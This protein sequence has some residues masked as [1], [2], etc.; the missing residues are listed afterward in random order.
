MRKSISRFLALLLTLALAIPMYS[1]LV[2][3]ASPLG[4]AV[5]NSEARDVPEAGATSDPAAKTTGPPEETPAAAVEEELGELPE[6]E[7][8]PGGLPEKEAPAGDEAEEEAGAVGE[9]EVKEEEG[10]VEEEVEEEDAEEEEEEG[11]ELY[12]QAV[13]SIE[14]SRIRVEVDEFMNFIVYQRD[15]SSW[16]RVTQPITAFDAGGATAPGVVGAWS[17]ALPWSSSTGV[18]VTGDEPNFIEA[19]TKLLSP[20]TSYITTGNDYREVANGQAGLPPEAGNA[21][22]EV[23]LSDNFIRVGDGLYESNVK[24]YT[25]KGAATGNRLTVEGVDAANSLKHTVVLE[26]G[27]VPGTIAVSSYYT[28]EGAGSFK[29]TKF[30]DN[31][32]KVEATPLENLVMGGDTKRTGGLWS[33]QGCDSGLSNSWSQGDKVFPVLDTMGAGGTVNIHANGVTT[34][35]MSRN[36]WHWTRIAG[37]A[38]NFLWGS[39]V[40]FGVGSLMPYHVFGLELPVRGSGIAGNHN[41]GYT[42]VGWPGKTLETGEMTYIGTSLIGV[43]DGDMGSGVDMYARTMDSVDLAPFVERGDFISRTDTNDAVPWSFM[44]GGRDYASP[45]YLTASAYGAN[46]IDGVPRDLITLPKGNELP[47]W[48]RKPAW[49]TFGYGSTIPPRTFFHLVPILAR[50]G[51]GSVVYESGWYSGGIANPICMP[52]IGGPT[53]TLSVLAPMLEEYFDEHPHSKHVTA[54]DAYDFSGLNTDDQA[55]SIR[56]VRAMNEYVHEH[57]MKVMGWVQNANISGGNTPVGGIPLSW[58][59]ANASNAR[60][61]SYACMGNPEVINTL[62][63]YIS[64]Y[65]FGDGVGELNFD[66]FKGDSFWGIERCF[67]TGHGH[68]GDPDAPIRNYGLFFKNLYDK[69]N[70]VKG[71]TAYVGGPIIDVE[72]MSV[73]KHC[74][75]GRIM[76]YYVYAG[77][78]RPI[79]GDHSGTKQNRQ[80]NRIFRGFYGWEVP[81][82]SDHHDLD[83]RDDE[84]F[85]PPLE[86]IGEFDYANLL[87]TGILFA[88]KTR[89]NLNV[90]ESSTSERSSLMTWPGED[91]YKNRGTDFTPSNGTGAN[92]N[93]PWAN[94]AIKWGAALKY[95]G[96]YN[97]FMPV[98]SRMIDNLYKYVVDYPEAYALELMDRNA[99]GSLTPKPVSERIYSFYATSFAIEE[100]EPRLRN[101]TGAGA[102][103]TVPCRFY[104]EMMLSTTNNFPRS[105]DPWNSTDKG[106]ENTTDDIQA[107]IPFTFKYEGPIEIR[108]LKASTAYCLTDIETGK[109]LLKTSDVNGLIKF[110]VVFKNSVIYH[111]TEANT[112]SISGYVYDGYGD[113]LSGATITLYDENGNRMF[114]DTGSDMDGFYSFPIVPTG[115]YTLKATFP[116]EYTQPLARTGTA[117]DYEPNNDSREAGY[118]PVNLDYFDNVDEDYTE[119][120]VSGNTATTMDIEFDTDE[121]SDGAIKVKVFKDLSMVVYRNEGT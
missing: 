110:D 86:N 27:N 82:D 111:V 79:H 89:I 59:V 102:W 101:V 46:D 29:I 16:K 11:Q 17:Y 52:R 87:G 96:L 45:R 104:R 18:T 113:I 93:L 71:A 105:F 119:V 66:G 98:Q 90:Y 77:I 106:I 6:K 1:P 116:K 57:G 75:C 68:D 41:I 23:L 43:V 61:S 83:M 69:A 42:W 15:G 72:K 4:D 28:Y 99:N 56:V 26:T 80:G 22:G 103:T 115:N 2:A 88:S 67:G 114:R 9:E 31:N 92:S 5:V 81:M 74:M 39:D 40:G 14:D 10:V 97:D 30:V 84:M 85:R 33:W 7:E 20:K 64:E 70:Y 50:L 58:C 63:T 12:A 112:G 65:V 121:I 118:T 32:F 53:T 21:T 36:N 25:S 19:S 3:L 73:M 37:V 35:L 34:N 49:E 48:A 38:Y 91:N 51:Y 8:G 100:D 76:D 24:T 47:G 107:G 44:V 55:G 109:K 95:Y 120:V 78:N 94:G 108:G 117:P 13:I 60:V 62:T 54:G